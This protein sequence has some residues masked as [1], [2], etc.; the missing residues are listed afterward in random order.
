MLLQLRFIAILSLHLKIEQKVWL[1]C[2]NLLLEFTKNCFLKIL[3]YFQV[4]W[5]KKTFED[6]RTLSPL[7]AAEG[8]DEADDKHALYNDAKINSVNR[9]TT[10]ELINIWA[11]DEIPHL[12]ILLLL[13]L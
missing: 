4:K 7:G 2:L 6:K 8:G 1:S 10:G 9:F 13:L 12:N 3:L 5:R 11:N